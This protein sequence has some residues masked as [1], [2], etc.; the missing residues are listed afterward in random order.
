M[1]LSPEQ[2]GSRER[3]VLE[4]HEHWKHLL[5]AGLI[6]LAALAGLLVVLALSPAS[7]FLSWL[8]TAG[9]IAFAVVVVVFGVWPFI[10]WRTRTYTL[11]NERLAMRRGVFRRSGRDIPLS[12]INDVAFEQTLWDRMIGAGSLTVE[13]AGE[14]GQETLHDICLLYTSDAADD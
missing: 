6:C 2:L 12:R 4:V 8:D 10:E 5:L 3:V 7:G 14:R 13:S 9:W 11:T 1:G